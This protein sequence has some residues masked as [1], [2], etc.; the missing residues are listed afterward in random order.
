MSLRPAIV[1][2]LSFLSCLFASAQNALP[3]T[4]VY[5]SFLGGNQQDSISAQALDTTGNVY[6]TGTT[7]SPNFP[8]TAG[9]YEPTF[10]G[11][12]NDSVIFVSK[13][14]PEGALIWSTYLGPGCSNF[15]VPSG[16]AVD[17]EQNVYVTG[18]FECPHFPTTLRIGGGG[19]IF[20]S[21]LNSTGSELLYSVSLGGQNI[22]QTSSLALD[23]FDDVFVTAA[24]ATS[25][26]NN[27]TG[28]IGPLGGIDDFWVAEIN[29][30]GSA[31]PWSVQIGGSGS[32]ES[33]SIVIDSANLI[34]VTGYSD[35]T[36]FPVTPGTIDQPDASTFVVKLNPA[37]N[38][39]L[40]MIYGA[41]I[42]APAGNTNAY[43]QPF[44]LAVDSFGDTYISNWTYNTGMYTSPNAFQP[45]PATLPDGYVFELNPTAS[46]IL[47]GT[48]MGGNGTD[49]AVGLSIDNS[50]NTYV[51]G[52]TNSWD[53]PVT[54][55]S[56]PGQA[57]NEEIAYYIKLNPQFAAVSSV[58]F[59]PNGTN[60]RTSSADLAGGAWFS[61]YTQEGFFSTLNA[62][63]P[64]DAGGY[65][66]FL[67][68]TN[69]A[70]LCETSMVALCN[71]VP[72]DYSSQ[73]IEFTAQAA[74]VEGATSIALFLDGESVFTSHAAQFDVWLPVALGNHTVSVISRSATG[75]AEK[76]NQTFYVAPSSACPLSPVVPSLTI[77]SPLNAASI[78]GSVSVSVEANDGAAPPTSL[79]LY[80]DGKYVGT[81]QN[82]NGTYSD[83]LTLSS[84]QHLIGVSGT[85][86]NGDYLKTS[87]AFKVQ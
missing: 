59:G 44:S 34:Y 87:A 20:V 33:A 31:V 41:L 28:I 12:R 62:Y 7:A 50:G 13:F 80:V 65:D 15:V 57:V 29:S 26:C 49:Y 32:D 46:A 14:S 5:S 74:D 38:P 39:S 42:G 81:L 43:I 16:I 36:N 61:G 8:T 64:Q 9:V 79:K 2:A 51:S 71:I 63:Q 52:F 27:Q 35:S 1:I 3:N 24:G 58:A 19:E 60:T 10:P 53:F 73:R 68:H 40:S 4:W 54:A 56:N 83:T 69:F 45:Q 37:K 85:D 30:E 22:T 77:C 11:P 70:G 66:G 67:L 48:Y 86:P 84:G 82:Q 18:T 6:V 17:S 78:T 75:A 23:S 72:S 25:C 21:K 55:Y 47:N 76:A